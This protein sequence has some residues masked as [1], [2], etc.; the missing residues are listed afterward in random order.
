[1]DALPALCPAASKSGPLASQPGPRWERWAFA[2][3]LLGIVWR[4][5]RFLLAFPIWG[6]EAF[7]CLDVTRQS[8]LHMSEGMPFPQVAP[9][10]FLWGERA[11]FFVLGSCEWAMRLLPFLAGMGGLLLFCAGARDLVAAA[12]DPGRGSP[13]R[14]SLARF[15][16]GQRQT[17]CLRPALLAPCW[18]LPSNGS[19]S[20]TGPG[21]CWCWPSLRPRWPSPAHRRP[22][23]SRPRSVLPWCFPSG[24]NRAGKHERCSRLSTSWWAPRSSLTTFWRPL[25]RR[26]RW[27]ASTVSSCMTTGRTAFRHRAPSPSSNGSS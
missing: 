10:L 19:A 11:A 23:S 1:M 2:L 9:I 13:R 3:L 26:M 4:T 17:L 14:G 5:V 16:V 7:I 20:A 25:S 22:S 8:F 15:H 18:F 24:V 21:G 6:D 12:S 27:T